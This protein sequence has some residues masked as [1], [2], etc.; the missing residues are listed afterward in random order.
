VSNTDDH[1]R[2]HAAFW[3]GDQLRL[4]PAYDICPQLRSGGETAQAMAIG[5]DGFRASQL[6]GCVN[7]SSTYLLSGD[8]A[9]SIINHQLDVINTQWND[10]ADAAQLTAAERQSLWGRQILNPFALYDYAAN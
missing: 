4:T 6:A 10:A 2:N 9:R 8:E 7:A 3:D 1:A 5:R